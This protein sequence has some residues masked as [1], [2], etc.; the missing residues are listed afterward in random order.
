MSYFP[1][2]NDVY[3]LKLAVDSKLRYPP[4]ANT[5]YLFVFSTPRSLSHI[6]LFFFFFFFYHVL[7]HG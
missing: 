2:V 7:V 4:L 3:I 1:L 5:N 6:V